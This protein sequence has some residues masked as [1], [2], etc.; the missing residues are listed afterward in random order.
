MKQLSDPPLGDHLIPSLLPEGYLLVLNDECDTVTFLDVR[1]GRVPILGQW[2]LSNQIMKLLRALLDAHPDYCSHQHFHALLYPSTPAL[3]E[4]SSDE[5]DRSKKLRWFLVEQLKA[6]LAPCGLDVNLITNSGYYL[7]YSPSVYVAPEPRVRYYAQVALFGEGQALALH[8]GL[9][10]ATLVALA[11]EARPIQAQFRFSPAAAQALVCLLDTYPYCCLYQQV[12]E[13]LYP[14]SAPG[15][16]E[17]LVRRPVFRAIEQLGKGLSAFGLELYPAR[18]LG[19]HLRSSVI[20]PAVNA[21]PLYWSLPWGAH[22]RRN[23]AKRPLETHGA[24]SAHALPR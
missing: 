12:Y 14:Q 15:L 21:V 18:D 2:R 1:Q 4:L 10:V 8:T 6:A 17:V 22:K 23:F 9:G 20:A 3:E 7:S 13:R 19:Y 5:R 24:R 16:S 11:E